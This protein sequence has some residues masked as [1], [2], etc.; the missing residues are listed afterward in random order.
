[1]DLALSDS[2]WEK[3]ILWMSGTV[4]LEFYFTVYKSLLECF[5][6]PCLSLFFSWHQ[7]FLLLAPYIWQL[8][9][10]LFSRTYALCVSQHIS[11]MVALCISII[12]LIQLKTSSKQ[13]WKKIHFFLTFKKFTSFILT[14]LHSWILSLYCE[15]L[16]CATKFILS[17][18]NYYYYYEMNLRVS[19]FIS[20]RHK[21]KT[22]NKLYL[23]NYVSIP[24]LKVVNI[25]PRTVIYKTLTFA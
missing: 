8:F 11:L 1:M 25:N 10:V 5:L 23:L 12:K 19:N 14:L 18:I 22:K 7:W 6:D 24:C 3:N 21:K 2:Y 9:F 20:S 13:I 15:F 17:F 16:N 4:T